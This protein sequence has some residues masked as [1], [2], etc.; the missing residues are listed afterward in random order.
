M[1][2][3]LVVFG[4]AAVDGFHVEGMAEDEL[5]PLLGAQIG[6]PISTE[7]ALDGNDQVW[8]EGFNGF[9]KSLR[10]GS[11]VAVKQDLPL[12]VEDTQIHRPSVQIDA[13][14]IG[15]GLGVE[16]HQA[17]SLWKLDTSGS[18]PNFYAPG[19][20][21]DEYQVHAADALRARPMLPC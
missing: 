1:G 18:I 17:S 3:D 10:T 5:D 14:V 9:Q 19:G 16:S 7:E 2:I 11:Q 13:A 6:Q 4:F 12:L 20:G 15:M 21:L 8:A